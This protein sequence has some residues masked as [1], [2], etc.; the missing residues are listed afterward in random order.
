VS[1]IPLWSQIYNV[2]GTWPIYITGLRYLSLL[3]TNCNVLGYWRH[4]SVLLHFFIYDFTSRHYN[5]CLQCV[6]TLWRCVSERSFDLFCYLFRDLLRWSLFSVFISVSLLSLSVLS[7]SVS[8]SLSSLCLSPL[9]SS[10]C[11]WNRRHLPPRLH[12]RCS[13]FPTIWLLRNSYQLNLC[14][15]FGKSLRR[16]LQIR[17]WPLSSNVHIWSTVY[18]ENRCVGSAKSVTIMS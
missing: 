7:L 15:V 4:R 2:G 11:A 16:K 9:K 3:N 18:S 1:L 6:I 8:L 10:V 13:G 17:T 12:F 14:R 5:L